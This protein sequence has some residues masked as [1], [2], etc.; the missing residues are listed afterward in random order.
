MHDETMRAVLCRMRWQSLLGRPDVNVA[1]AKNGSLLNTDVPIQCLANLKH[2]TTAPRTIIEP[3][4]DTTKAVQERARKP[5]H[6][7]STQD[8][9][10]KLFKNEAG[11]PRFARPHQNQRCG[12]DAAKSKPM[13]IMASTCPSN[14]IVLSRFVLVLF[15]PSC[16]RKKSQPRKVRRVPVAKQQE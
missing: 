8:W 6:R 3:F 12:S 15:N 1:L 14:Q 2:D 5:K 10:G 9:A 4:N 7:S 13:K 11:L 16:F